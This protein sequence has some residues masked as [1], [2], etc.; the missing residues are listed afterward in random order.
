M[1]GLAND[2]TENQQTCIDVLCA[3][4][5][6]PYDPDPGDDAEPDIRSAYRAN[7][8]VRHTI[9]RLIGAH[10]REDVAWSW[11]GLDFDFTGVVF[12]GGDFNGAKFSGGTVR[13]HGAEFSSGKVYFSGAD[14]SGGAVS[15]GHAEFSGGTV[16][17]DGAEFS[18]GAVT[19]GL[20]VNAGPATFSGV[21]IHFGGAKFSGGKVNFRN[22]LR[23]TEPPE[24][25]WA[26]AD[27]PPAGC[28]LPD[29]AGAK[30]RH[31]PGSAAS[32]QP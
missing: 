2:W 9:I 10:L 3:Y 15:F 16:Y 26:D 8:E 7:R 11:E 29:N 20:G 31:E 18:G 5:R 22:P 32:R 1:A 21:A 25:D 14:F 6:L 30:A 19:F 4:L 12:D 24:F 27:P 17:F 28:L 23:W 13:F